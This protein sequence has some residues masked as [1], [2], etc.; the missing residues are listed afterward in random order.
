VCA[1]GV[2]RRK[3]RAGISR[4]KAVRQRQE[5]ERLSRSHSNELLRRKRWGISPKSF[6]GDSPR[7]S[8]GFLDMPMRAERETPIR[9]GPWNASMARDLSAVH[10]E[11]EGSL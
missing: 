1:P 7:A 8:S 2:E 11:K 4:P 6:K 9:D 10:F 5:N 3:N